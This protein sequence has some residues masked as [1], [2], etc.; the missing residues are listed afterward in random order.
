[1]H[2]TTQ[3]AIASL[4]LAAFAFLTPSIASAA[5]ERWTIELSPVFFMDNTGD[6]GAPPLP[7]EIPFYCTAGPPTCP[8]GTPQ[9]TQ[10]LRLDYSI[11]YQINKR[12][13]VSYAHT[14]FDIS[15]G[16]ISSIQPFSVLTGSLNDRIDAGTLNYAAG[17]GLNFSLAYTSHQ[18]VEFTAQP[19]P[20]LGTR[21]FLNEEQCNDGTSNPQSI[22]SN[23]YSIGGTYAFGPHTAYQP[24]MFKIGAQAFYYPRTPNA[25]ACPGTPGNPTG[26]IPGYQPACN[27][28]GINGYVGSGTT[29]PWSVTFFPLSDFAPNVIKPGTIPFIGYEDANVWFHAENTP[30]TFNQVVAGLVQVLPHGLSLSYTYVKLNGRLSSDTVPTPDSIRSAVSIFKLTYDLHF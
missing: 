28:N 17:H 25:V 26:A 30:E 9:T 16:R 23:Y 12:W 11:A 5:Q 10:N 29:Y 2:R 21:C 6:S 27:S 18:R 13:S 19:S 8:G 24:P 3:V 20:L 7:G 15:L 4:V 1:M 22:N 14:N